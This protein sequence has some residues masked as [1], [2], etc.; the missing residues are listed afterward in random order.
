MRAL[1]VLFLVA[2]AFAGD[3]RPLTDDEMRNAYRVSV[4]WI[5]QH[6]KAPTSAHFADETEARFARSRKDSIDVKLYVDAQNAYGAML[7]K[8]WLCR[9]SPRDGA[10][11]VVCIE[12]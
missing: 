11:G 12:R 10:Y 8:G 6:L 2:T 5:Y 1:C 7:R 4:D 3:K 9:V